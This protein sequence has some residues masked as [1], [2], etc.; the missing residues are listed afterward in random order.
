MSY[1]GEYDFYV[2]RAGLD[3]TATLGEAKR[4]YFLSQLDPAPAGPLSLGELEFA[5]YVQETGADPAR[6]FAAAR[7]DF[8]SSEV[9]GGPADVGG[10]MAAYFANPPI[11]GPTLQLYVNMNQLSS[12]Q[13]EL[14]AEASGFTPDATPVPTVWVAD[15]E[16]GP[17]TE[18][19][20]LAEYDPGDGGDLLPGWFSTFSLD[21]IG[22]KYIQVRSTQQGGLV[23]NT[24]SYPLGAR[25][26]FE[27]TSVAEVPV[28]PGVST[29]QPMTIFATLVDG[30]T[31]DR[32]VFANGS[33]THVISTGRAST[34]TTYFGLV[35]RSTG[36]NAGVTITLPNSPIVALAVERTE[37]EARLHLYESNGDYYTNVV[38]VN[39]WPSV[40]QI[41]KLAAG[42]HR[43][44]VEL[45]TGVFGPGVLLGR[46]RAIWSDLP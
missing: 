20:T 16:A 30:V 42:A 7:L 26:V 37:N 9:P 27:T 5:F 46:L 33:D 25:R 24:E 17:W 4:A 15:A 22:G 11:A 39:G 34:G 2:E 14:F 32:S 12:W 44:R 13:S 8:Y 28:T 40:G 35:T 38:A 6:G 45:W 29:A 3:R 19:G 10:L 23:S 18:V 31:D 21:V 1:P 43:T 41:N 36:A